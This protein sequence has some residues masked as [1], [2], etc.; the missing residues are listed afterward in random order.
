[1]KRLLF[2]VHR[3]PY[4]PNKG[5]KIRSFNELKFLSHHYSVD[6]LA[7]ADDPTDLKYVSD[8]QQY[9]DR[10]KVFQLNSINAKVKGGVALLAGRSLSSRYFYLKE[11]QSTFNRWIQK[12]GYDVVFCFSS[13]M[14]EYV[15]RSQVFSKHYTGITPSLVMDFCD[16]DSDKWR[17]YA[18]ESSFPLKLLYGIESKR[19]KAYEIKIHRFFDRTVLSS[20]GEAELFRTNCPDCKNISVIANGVDHSYFSASPEISRRSPLTTKL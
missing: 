17:Q 4:P 2:V 9:C 1:M 11:M 13:S 8:L 14:A 10:V 16:V 5:D 3:I 20:P 15:F 18:Q 7:L 6:L 19:L 12:R